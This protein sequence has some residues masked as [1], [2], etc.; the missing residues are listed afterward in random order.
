[1]NNIEFSR[2]RHILGRTQ[3]QMSRLLCV[4]PKAIQSFEQGWRKIPTHIGRE[5]LLLLALKKPING[6]LAAC[7][8]ATDCPEEWKN[9]CIV[10]ELKVRHF[11]WYLNSTF[12]QGRLQ[13]SWENKIQ[14]CQN[15]NVYKNMFTDG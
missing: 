15:C 5:M 1:M 13:E 12:C 2:I 8:D 3:E 11:C 14:L 9:N 4:S 7:W 6:E 10:W